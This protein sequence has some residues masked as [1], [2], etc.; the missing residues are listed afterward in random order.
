[1]WWTT[2][3]VTLSGPPLEHEGRRILRKVE[4]SFVDRWHIF[5]VPNAFSWLK[6]PYAF[7]GHYELLVLSQMRFWVFLWLRITAVSLRL[8]VWPALQHQMRP[9]QTHSSHFVTMPFSVRY[10]KTCLIYLLLKTL[11]G[12][13]IVPWCLFVY[14]M[15]T[16]IH[17]L[18]CDA[19]YFWILRDAAVSWSSHQYGLHFSVMRC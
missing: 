8:F 1:M 16:E 12:T 17:L 11:N 15:L 6:C 9:H 18:S 13:A 5:V 14:C 3:V 10:I 7:W 4:L 2:P 19:L